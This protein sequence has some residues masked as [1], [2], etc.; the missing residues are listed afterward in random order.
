MGMS[1]RTMIKDIN[2]TLEKLVWYTDDGTV[3]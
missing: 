1:R 3:P 2:D